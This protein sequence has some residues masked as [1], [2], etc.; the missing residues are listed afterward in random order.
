[1]IAD[2]PLALF[3][4][5]SLDRR[6]FLP[7]GVTGYDAPELLPFTTTVRVVDRVH[8]HARTAGAWTHVTLATGLGQGPGSCWSGFRK[9]APDRGQAGVDTIA[10]IAPM[11]A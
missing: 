9:T 10:K 2:D 7:H 4:R 5:V 3:E 6:V 11:S 1:M 8:D